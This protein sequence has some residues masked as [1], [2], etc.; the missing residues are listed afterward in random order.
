MSTKVVVPDSIISSAARRVPARTN[1]GET[2]LASAGKDVLVQPVHQREV[3]RQPAVQRHR[4]VGVGVDQARQDQL[5]GRVDGVGAAELLGDGLGRVHA[6]DVGAVDG[7]RAVGDHPARGIHRDDG[8]AGDEQRHLTRRSLSGEH[9]A[10]AHTTSATKAGSL[11]MVRILACHASGSMSAVPLHLVTH[12]VA[13]DALAEL[14]HKTTRPAAFRAAAHRIS[15]WWPPKRCA[16]CRR[17]P[18]R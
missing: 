2:V 9:R 10:A 13:L 6:N 4:R 15:T 1:S 12:P 11:P 8:A 7:H 3:V 5:A 16:T 17:K 14:R 18:A